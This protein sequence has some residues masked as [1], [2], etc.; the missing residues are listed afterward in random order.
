METSAE[1]NVRL[2]GQ[3]MAAYMRHFAAKYLRGHIRFET[4]VLKIYRENGSWMVLVKNL[5]DASQERL[6]FDKLVLC[7]GVNFWSCHPMIT[8]SHRSN[9]LG[10]QRTSSARFSLAGQSKRTGLPGTC[11]PLFLLRPP[12]GRAS[13]DGKRR[14][15]SRRGRRRG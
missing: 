15:E 2:T 13:F 14:N 1:S 6:S 9:L 4:E 11:S 5:R 12:S 7:T 10:M 3:D 8:N